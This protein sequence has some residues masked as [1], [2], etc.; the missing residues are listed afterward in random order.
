MNETE[1]RALIRKVFSGFHSLNL[2][3]LMADLRQGF[4]IAN[5]WY[6]G[7]LSGF[8]KTL[9]PVAH[10]WR[11]FI[12]DEKPKEVFSGADACLLAGVDCDLGQTFVEWWD[13]TINHPLLLSELTAMY[14]ERLDDADV[15][16][17]VMCEREPCYA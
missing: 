17:G 7:G 15:V 3:F 4:V 16:Q 14:R 1:V 10:G 11:R 13:K 6:A 5:T 8:P 2:L 12:A 9:C